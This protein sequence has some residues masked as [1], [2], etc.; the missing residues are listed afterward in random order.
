MTSGEF[1]WSPP[2]HDR[3]NTELLAEWNEANAELDKM[4]PSLHPEHFTIDAS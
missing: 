4:W 3:S 2:R 1:T